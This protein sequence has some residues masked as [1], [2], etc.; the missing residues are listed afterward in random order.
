MT[1]LKSLLKRFNWWNEIV[2]IPVGLAAFYFYPFLAMQLEDNPAVYGVGALQIIVFAFAL[3]AIAS[4][5][6]GIFVK[7][8]VP[9]IFRFKDNEF[10]YAFT[11]LTSY[12]KCV[13][14][15]LWFAVYFFGFILSATAL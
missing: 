12:Q 3:S 9:N 14:L 10:E 8:I 7:V 5:F 15:L 6:G 2:S 13:L 4:G 11:T 1:R